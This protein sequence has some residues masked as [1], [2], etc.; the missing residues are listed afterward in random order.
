M[1]VCGTYLAQATAMC[2]ECSLNHE[3]QVGATATTCRCSRTVLASGEAVD[4]HGFKLLAGLQ[5]GGWKRRMV[6]RIRIMLR[7]QTERIT[8]AID[9]PALTGYG[10]IQEVTG[11]ELDSRLIGEHL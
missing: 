3:E 9:F 2:L 6:G 8:P 1:A 11:I 5:L 4:S 7:L 10:S